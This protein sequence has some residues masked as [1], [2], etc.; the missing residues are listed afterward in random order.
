MIKSFI[1][2][3][4]HTY[5]T[6]FNENK[7]W[8]RRLFLQKMGGVL[9]WYYILYCRRVE[10]KKCADTGIGLRERCCRIKSPIILPHGLAGI[11]IARNVVIGRNVTIFQHVT[12]A[13]ADRNKKTIVD[14]DVIIGA[15]AVILNNAHI[16]KGAKIGAN[17]VVI[18]DIPPGCTAVGVPARII[19]KIKE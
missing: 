1:L 6:S 8:K 11:I 16:G 15:G 12:I 5:Q 13:E 9:S 14:D 3:C 4:I 2:D 10:S 19:K 18:E 7:Y 17:A